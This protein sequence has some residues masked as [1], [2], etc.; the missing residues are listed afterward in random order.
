MFGKARRDMFGCN[1]ATSWLEIPTILK[2]CG[3]K[4]MFWSLQIVSQ[5]DPNQCC[6]EAFSDVFGAFCEALAAKML[7]DG[8][9]V[10]PTANVTHATVPFGG[11]GGNKNWG[12]LSVAWGNR[13]VHDSDAT[14]WDMI[15]HYSDVGWCWMIVRYHILKY[16]KRRGINRWK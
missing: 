15:S 2:P 10:I 8:P 16:S 4:S 11:N 1:N 13:S 5:V 12:W 14:I 7:A 9:L 6:P 3:W